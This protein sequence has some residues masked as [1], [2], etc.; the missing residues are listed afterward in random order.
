MQQQ[1]DE[2]NEQLAMARLRVEKGERLA[3]EQRARVSLVNG[4]TP[5][6]DRIIHEVSRLEQNPTQERLDYISELTDNIN[7]QTQV[8]THWIQL[9]QGE[10]SLHIET[11]ALQP[12]FDIVAMGRRSF[13][14]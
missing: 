7:E 3:L 8:L 11:F 6:I 1:E 5:L 12:L 13:G 4:I 2:L 10:L 14:M 9:R